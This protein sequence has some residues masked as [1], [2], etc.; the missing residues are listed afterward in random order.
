MSNVGCFH[1]VLLL[2]M[3]LGVTLLNLSV[4]PSV[5]AAPTQTNTVFDR[6]SSVQAFDWNRLRE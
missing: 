1:L 3:P 6:L 4:H 5:D 2:K